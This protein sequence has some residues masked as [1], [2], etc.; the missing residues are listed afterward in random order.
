MLNK[1]DKL[2]NEGIMQAIIN[3]KE[4]YEFAEIIPISALKQDNVDR[5]IEITKKYL[6]RIL[7]LM[8]NLGDK[9]GAIKGNTLNK[10][11]LDILPIPLPPIEEQERIVNKIELILPI[12]DEIDN[13]Y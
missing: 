7:P 2:T 10:S 9:K 1:I 13:M 5:L 6:L 3:Y 11:S 8:S 4:L 12:I